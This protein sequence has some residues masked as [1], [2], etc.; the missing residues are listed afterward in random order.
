MNQA[1]CW[2]A[3][4]FRKFVS[5]KVIDNVNS[6]D[7]VCIT[8]TIINCKYRRDC[9]VHT[10]EHRCA[11]EMMD[12]GEIRVP[13]LCQNFWSIHPSTSDSIHQSLTMSLPDE[14]QRNIRR[15]QLLKLINDETTLAGLIPS[16]I[17][18]HLFFILTHPPVMIF[19]DVVGRR[20]FQRSA[21][22][23]LELQKRHGD[24]DLRSVS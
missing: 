16:D 18:S 9:K 23:A 24:R 4:S 3:S 8:S 2:F 12:P 7:K 10:S 22:T 14:Q 20:S 19:D 15:Y 21:N 5:K 6:I 11:A 17:W 13:T 1:F